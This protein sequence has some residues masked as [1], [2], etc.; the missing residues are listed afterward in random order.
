M[1]YGVQ[2]N[3]SSLFTILSWKQMLAELKTLSKKMAVIE[4]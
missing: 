3:Y 2:T 1:L 4:L